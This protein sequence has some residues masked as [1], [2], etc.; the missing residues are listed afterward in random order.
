MCGPIATMPNLPLW[1]MTFPYNYMTHLGGRYQACTMPFDWTPQQAFGVRNIFNPFFGAFSFMSALQNNLYGSYNQNNMMQNAI[2]LGL[3]FGFNNGVDTNI[4]SMVGEVGKFV[5][6]VKRGIDSGKLNNEQKAKMKELEREADRIQQRLQDLKAL[7]ANGTN[8]AQVQVIL[9]QIS[10]D[11]N[12]LKAKAQQ[13]AQEIKETQGSNNGVDN[14]DTTTNGANE[15]TKEEK[16]DAKQICKKLDKAIIAAGTYYDDDEEG[17]L[18]VMQQI[19]ADNVMT[20]LD[21][22]ENSYAKYGAYAGDKKG[23]I[24]SLMDDCEGHQKEEIAGILID[25]LEKRANDLGIDADAEVANARMSTHAN[26]LGWRDDDKICDTVNALIKKIKE[27]SK[28]KEQKAT[29]KTE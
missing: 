28:P 1:S 20:V 26:W 12:G 2:Q 9:S 29:E 10:D 22:W 17:L 7:K 16:Y 27:G 6:D 21:T 13:L 23:F 25:A 24:E 5:D 8:P 18:P 15:P 3:S 14:P 4:G 19:N 11:F